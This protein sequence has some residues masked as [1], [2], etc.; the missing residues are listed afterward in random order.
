MVPP[1]PISTRLG[2]PSLVSTSASLLALSAGGSSTETSAD[3]VIL[4]PTLYPLFILRISTSGSL[5]S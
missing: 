1:V 2:S 5:N 4:I 3:A